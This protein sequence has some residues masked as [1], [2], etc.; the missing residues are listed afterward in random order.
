M[1]IECILLE[2]NSIIL[3]HE[4]EHLLAFCAHTELEK[5]IFIL[6]KIIDTGPHK[7]H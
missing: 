2:Q 6:N 3:C 7:I 5:L 4:E 1:Y